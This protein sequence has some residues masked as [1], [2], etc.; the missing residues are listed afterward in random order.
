MT[1][2]EN[3]DVSDV[4]CGCCGEVMI[5]LGNRLVVYVNGDL[6]ETDLVVCDDCYESFR[7]QTRQQLFSEN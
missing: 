3:D 6:F 1:F 7:V 5:S 4:F 2:L